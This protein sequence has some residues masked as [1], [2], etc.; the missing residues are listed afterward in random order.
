VMTAADCYR[1]CLS[2]PDVDL[3]LTG[4]KTRQQLEEN[5]RDI[6]EK[7]PLSDD[8]KKWMSEFGQTVHK[9]SSRFTFRF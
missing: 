8:E 2:N 5:L 6:K 3:T 1:F 4:P 7:G 9:A